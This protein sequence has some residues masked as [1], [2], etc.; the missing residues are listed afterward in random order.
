MR[1]TF[2]IVH[3]FRFHFIGLL[4][5]DLDQESFLT[6]QEFE[7]MSMSVSSDGTMDSLDAFPAVDAK[8]MLDSMPTKREEQTG[9]PHHRQLSWNKLLLDSQSTLNGDVVYGEIK[10]GECVFN[11]KNE[12]SNT[13][14][15][16]G[17]KEATTSSHSYHHRTHSLSEKFSDANIS[18]PKKG[19]TVK[20]KE[21]NHERRDDVALKTGSSYPCQ[22]LTSNLA[23][24]EGGEDDNCSQEL[25]SSGKKHRRMYSGGVSNPTTA[26]RRINSRGN[27]AF[28]DRLGYD[29]RPIDDSPIPIGHQFPSYDSWQRSIALDRPRSTSPRPSP[30][31]YS[32]DEFLRPSHGRDDSFIDNSFLSGRQRTA[33]YNTKADFDTS[34][35]HPDDGAYLLHSMRRSPPVHRSSSDY[36]D[37]Y[38]A[39]YGYGR[40]SSQDATYPPYQPP[41]PSSS[42]SD[43]PGYNRP[44]RPQHSHEGNARPPPNSMG[45]YHQ[46]SS[47]H[48][49]QQQYPLKYDEFSPLPTF[50]GN[51]TELGSAPSPSSNPWNDKEWKGFDYPVKVPA[52]NAQHTK[53]YP[54]PRKPQQSS[55]VSSQHYPIQQSNHRQSYP[56][57]SSYSHRNTSAVAARAAEAASRATSL[58]QHPLANEAVPQ[59]P[60]ANRDVSISPIE[61]KIETDE[62]LFQRDGTS[63]NARNYPPRPTSNQPPYRTSPQ[64]FQEALK[65][66][67]FLESPHSMGYSPCN[68]LNVESLVYS[69]V[70]PNPYVSSTVQQQHQFDD[71]TNPH[72]RKTESSV[73]YQSFVEDLNDKMKHTEQL[74]NR[75]RTNST[76]SL[77]FD[78]N[79]L[80]G[81]QFISGRT[82][83]L[84]PSVPPVGEIK[85][86]DKHGTK[87]KTVKNAQ[88]KGGKKDKKSTKSID[89]ASTSTRRNING[90]VSKRVRRKC[91]HDGCTNRVVQGG[92]CIQHGA[93][94]KICGYEG[95]T[96]HVK[97]AGMCSTHGPARKRCEFE[98]CEKVA[99]QGGRCIAHGAKK[100]LCSFENC[101]KQAIL[102]GMCK[103]HHDQ[104]QTNNESFGQY[105]ANQYCMAV[106]NNGGFKENEGNSPNDNG[107]SSATPSSQH[108][109]GLSIFQDMAAVNTII[110]S[111]E[112]NDVNSSYSTT[113]SSS[114]NSRQGPSLHN[115][116]LSIFADEEIMGKIVDKG[117][118]L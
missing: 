38:N 117:L 46:S 2:I 101:E 30:K 22:Q 84:S 35:P 9:K 21:I 106:G 24:K 111:N 76:G 37:T 86:N 25:T 75:Q 72:H 73:I 50:S 66:N 71:Q 93:K 60:R 6:L 116:G 105:S 83:S 29:N 52:Y 109:R 67:G 27:A 34:G 39:A 77:V 16:N 58:L 113:S 8:E 102:S 11:I 98:G 64:L 53:H 47:S 95:C 7:N 26:H 99:V 107:A 1:L 104:S 36:V 14:T 118:G 23:K 100:R 74:P 69:L 59:R 114:P 17:S 88:S 20:F 91:T 61:S 28:I 49:P 87:T 10:T 68:D 13:T 48:P 110:G 18:G 33:A 90:E 44:Y 19:T 81:E 89:P 5:F 3:C 78:D 70:N 112:R 4:T 15:P 57:H 108:R 32:Q 56:P 85:S 82:P 96:K 103:K 43:H 54:L 92:V 31:D 42:Y 40:Q 12:S 94:R 55:S 62:P 45:M 65:G 63:S 80:H 41:L 51:P 115:R 79:S 97:K